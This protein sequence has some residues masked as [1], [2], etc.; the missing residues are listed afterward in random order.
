M[1]RRLPAPARLSEPLGLLDR[2]IPDLT[3]TAELPPAL[4]AEV[5]YLAGRAAASAIVDPATDPGVLARAPVTR[6]DSAAA[7]EVLI[8]ALD[9]TLSLHGPAAETW[10]ASRVGPGRAAQP[11]PDHRTPLPT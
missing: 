6:G 3:S 7:R 2:G 1:G 10:A 8:G 9:Q 5:D 4:A 11:H